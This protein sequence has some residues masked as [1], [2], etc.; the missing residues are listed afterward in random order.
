MMPA[1]TASLTKDMRQLGHRTALLFLVVSLFALTVRPQ[2][3][4]HPSSSRMEADPVRMPTAGHTHLRRSRDA[5]S[6]VPLLAILRRR[7][8][9]CGQL[10]EHCNVVGRLEGKGHAVG[11]VC[12]EL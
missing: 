12:G 1:T 10:P 5:G 8:R 9:L 2:S 6:D 4:R 11:L 3:A 7:I